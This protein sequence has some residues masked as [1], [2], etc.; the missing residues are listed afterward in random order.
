[1]AGKGHRMNVLVTNTQAAQSYAIITALRP[2]ANRI[3]VTVDRGSGIS[4]RLPQAAYSRFVDKRHSVPSAIEDWRMGNLTK[5]NTEAE[6]RYVQVLARICQKEKIDVIIP[7][8]DPYVYVLS[9]NKQFFQRMG[10][11]IP[12]PDYDITVLALDKY[13]TIQAAQ[14]VGFPCPR[15]Y[16]YQSPDDLKS[17]VNRETF[18]LVI[19]PRVGSGGRGMTIVKDYAELLQKLPLTIEKHGNPMIQEYIPGRERLSFAVLLDRS[20]ELKAAFNERL[21]RN[22]RVTARFGTVAEGARLDSQLINN[23][24]RLLRRLGWW[25]AVSVGTIRDARDG[26]Y[27]LM[28]INPRHSRN[29]WRRIAFGFNEPLSC[30]KIAKRESF[31][32]V[33]E[34]PKG[35]L[36]VCPVEDIQLLA[37]QLLDLLVYRL[38]VNFLKHRTLDE[39]S[40]PKTINEQIR[41]FTSTYRSS[42]R[43]LLDPNFRYFLKDPLVSILWWIRFSGWVLAAVKHVGK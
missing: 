24:E 6:E 36:F 15:T 23:A 33:N 14:E 25:G 17:I 26:Q 5:E 40:A 12:V 38:R 32:C 4:G 19:K 27:K 2:H 21:V 41:S 16:L 30:I 39:F 31:E 13:L 37:L 20:G 34:Y 8:W 10:V 18:P 11:V 35:V 9:K 29:M 3:V 22:F 42:K 7:S 1:M 43:K 28:E